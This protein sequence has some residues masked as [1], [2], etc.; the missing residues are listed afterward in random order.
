MFEIISISNST[1]P[2]WHSNVCLQ[3]FRT[4]RSPYKNIKSYAG[5][6]QAS[7]IEFGAVAWT[8]LVYWN[9]D[10]TQCAYNVPLWCH[11]Q[12]TQS[13]AGSFRQA[14]AWTVLVYLSDDITKSSYWTTTKPV[15]IPIF[16]D[17][18]PFSALS[19]ILS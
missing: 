17:M 7:N 11:R 3:N 19:L 12:N 10:L 5:R 15:E 18:T 1:V 13:C 14:A 8:Q 9:D 6:L 2:A 4:W 16:L